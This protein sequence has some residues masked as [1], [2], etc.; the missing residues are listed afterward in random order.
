MVAEHAPV[1]VSG[2]LA[3]ALHA[4][5]VRL[6]V[7]L[8]AAVH[9]GGASVRAAALAK[10]LATVEADGTLHVALLSTLRV[11]NDDTLT[12]LVRAWAANRADEFA[13]LVAQRS[14]D[15]YLR[16]RAASVLARLRLPASAARGTGGSLSRASG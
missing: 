7:L 9:D 2:R 5:S 1:A 4:G 13:T 14:H 6:P 16:V 10:A 15:G 12:T 11:M 8:E 3:E